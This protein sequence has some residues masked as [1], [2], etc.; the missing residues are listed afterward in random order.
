MTK[1]GVRIASDKTN[2]Y[3]GK[4]AW[5]KKSYHTKKEIKCEAVEK[6]VNTDYC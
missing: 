3:S 2:D 1:E 6:L 5:F 4:I